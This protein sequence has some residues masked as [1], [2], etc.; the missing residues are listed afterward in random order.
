MAISAEQLNV[1]LSARDKEFQRKM[2]DAER[3]VAYFKNRSNRNL[4]SVGRSFDQLGRAARVLAPLLAGVF[5]V[6]TLKNLTQSAAQ[7]GKLADLA[8]TS[9]EDLQLFAAGAR[10]VGFEMDKVADIIKDVNDKVGDFLATGGG[11]MK[12]F[13]ENIAPQVGVTAEQFARLSGPEALQLYVSSLEKANLSQAEMTFYMEALAN[14]STALLPLLRDNGKAM[15]ELGDEAKEAGRILDQ[16]AVDGSRE[17][18]SAVRDLSEAFDAEL[19]NAFI[20]NEDAL[21]SLVKYMEEKAVPKIGDFV[22]MLGEGVELFNLFTQ[23]KLPSDTDFEG[24]FGVPQG[25]GAPG[26]G[27]PSLSPEDAARLYGGSPEDYPIP[28]EPIVVT[29][30]S[31]DTSKTKDDDDSSSRR[32]SATDRLADLR[33]EYKGL[34]DTLANVSDA[35]RNFNDA[36]DILNRALKAGAITQAEYNAAMSTARQRFEDATLA[37]SDLGVVMDQVQ[38]SME[39]AFMSMIDGTMSAKDAFRSMA[40]DIIRELYRVLVVQ[41]LVGSFESGGGGILGSIFSGL[42]GRASGGS[43]QAGQAYMTGESGRELFVPQT[44]GRILSPAQTSNMMRAGGE[45]VI[46]QQTINVSTG[47][48]QTVRTEIKSLMPQIAESAKSAVVDAKRRGGSY[49]RAF[50]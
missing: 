11:P 6:Q 50:A 47:V 18:E 10:T 31:P 29:P 13:F 23:G 27:E 45:S 30:K 44:N 36:Q 4:S 38:S 21:V 8:G 15:K 5:T 48:Q 39:S 19:T 34:I 17:L 20:E 12:D 25:I 7:I 32:K 46:V 24:M 43:V 41:R 26:S 35:Q 3:R 2:R 40:A 1:I 42:S 37:A 14:D 49:G 33:E 9:A 16:D 22:R 28:L